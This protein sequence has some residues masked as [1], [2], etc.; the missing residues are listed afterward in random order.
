MDRR[1]ILPALALGSA[2]LVGPVTA[3]P[4]NLN[5]LSGN[6]VGGVKS[7]M[8]DG[9]TI[10]ASG[11]ADTA[12]PGNNGLA[13][14]NIQNWSGS[15][16]GVCN[17]DE[18][19]R[20]QSNDHAIDNNADHDMVLLTFSEAVVLDSFRLGWWSND[21]DVTLLAYGGAEAVYDLD[22]RQ[23]SQLV[24][25]DWIA[26]GDYFNNGTTATSTGT[27]IASTQWL[28]GAYNGLFGAPDVGTPDVTTNRW[29][30]TTGR[31]RT[32][33][34][35]LSTVSFSVPELPPP[36]PPPQEVPEPGSLALLALGVLGLTTARRRRN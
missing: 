4:L 22:G 15:G 34:L 12:R 32:D 31:E 14:G 16:I 13:Q 7:Y 1:Y 8:V 36:P 27:G 19:P 9:I 10:T 23:W 26:V 3:A 33:Y 2:F 17:G 29:G 30:W 25:D 18:Q 28:I 20:C 21:S 5:L 35:K 6:P 24:G 11:W